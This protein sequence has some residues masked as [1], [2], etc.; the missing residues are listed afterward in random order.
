MKKYFIDKIQALGNMMSSH[1]HQ[2][3]LFCRQIHMVC[4]KQLG[5]PRW[6]VLQ[7]MF[8]TGVQ[9]AIQNRTNQI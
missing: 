4:I 6:G 3:D 1:E 2:Q 7:E 8:G 5:S 9:Q